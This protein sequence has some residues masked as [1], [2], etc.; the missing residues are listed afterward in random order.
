MAKLIYNDKIYTSFFN[1]VDRYVMLDRQVSIALS[2]PR[3]YKG[4]HCRLLAPT[5]E[6]LKG[7]KNGEITKEQY[8]VIYYETTLALLNPLEIYEM[9]KGKVLL[10]WEKKGVFCHRHLVI[11][12]LRDNLGEGVIGGEL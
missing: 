7:Y 1:A 2:S 3:S 8:E 4:S 10:C 6:L 9:L 11:R 5:P 12:W